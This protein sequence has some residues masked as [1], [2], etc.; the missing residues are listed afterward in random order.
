M[1]RERGHGCLVGGRSR[2]SNCSSRIARSMR[3]RA[4]SDTRLRS[5]APHLSNVRSSHAAR[6]RR[7]GAG[8]QSFMQYSLPRAMRHTHALRCAACRLIVSASVTFDPLASAAPTIGTIQLLRLVRPLRSAELRPEHLEEPSLLLTWSAAS[9]FATAFIFVGSW[10]LL[11]AVALRVLPR[12]KRRRI[13]SDSTVRI[14]TAYSRQSRS[15]QSRKSRTGSRSSRS[16]SAASRAR[17]RYRRQ[18]GQ[19][20][21]RTDAATMS[22]TKA[23]RRGAI[24]S[25]ARTMSR[26]SMV[27]SF[28]LR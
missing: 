26:A 21:P 15:N 1:D 5:R 28:T 17:A 8:V 3:T 11:R 19:R 13:V 25:W 22:G 27:A 24:S 6:R 7:R 20:A 12:G 23:R 9:R 16:A 18:A 14:L 4:S 2:V 10:M